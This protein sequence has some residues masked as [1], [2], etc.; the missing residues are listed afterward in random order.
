MREKGEAR[1]TRK[2]K[3]NLKGAAQPN[4]THNISKPPC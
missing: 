2:Q 4:A 1:L 3:K